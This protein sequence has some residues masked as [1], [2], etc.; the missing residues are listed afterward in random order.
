M[1]NVQFGQ[2]LTENV[3]IEIYGL[4]GQLMQTSQTRN[5][6]ANATLNLSDYADGVYLVKLKTDSD[7]LVRRIAVQN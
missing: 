4:N 6:A 5:G 1:V 7:V 2:A 3:T